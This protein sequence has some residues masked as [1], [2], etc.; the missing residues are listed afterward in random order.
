MVN[1]E[2][3]RATSQHQDPNGDEFTLVSERFA[4]SIGV[5]RAWAGAAYSHP[6]AI[7]RAGHTTKIVDLVMVVRLVAILAVSLAAIVGTVRR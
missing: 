5:R 7:V 1:F 2:R 4:I 3:S 6:A